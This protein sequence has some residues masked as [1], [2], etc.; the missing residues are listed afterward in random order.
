MEQIASTL[1]QEHK[2]FNIEFEAI[3]E[4]QIEFIDKLI[5]FA[6]SKG[7]ITKL[8]TYNNKPHYKSDK[9]APVLIIELKADIDEIVNIGRS[10]QRE[11]FKN[12]SE[13]IYE[14]VPQYL[15]LESLLIL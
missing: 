8:T 10:I 4:K 3:G 6:N 15:S 2:K 12:N 1:R 9:P 13:T 7:F 11:I 14:V 5:G